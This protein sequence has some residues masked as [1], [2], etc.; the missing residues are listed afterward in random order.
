MAIRD[1]LLSVLK[2]REARRISFSL[3]A[4]NGITISV[5]TSSFQRVS[6]AIENNSV[7]IVEG[8]VAAGW[9]QYDSGNNTFSVGPG[10]HW[11]RAFNALLVHE[12]VHA[13][14]DLSRS[15]LPWL[16]N[17]TAAYIAQGYYLR[18]SGFSRNR[19]N[20]T[21]QPYLGLM[22][23]DSIISGGSPDQFWIS[24]LHGSLLSSRQY[25]SYIRTD[26]TGDG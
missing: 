22:I 9:A 15:S 13:S 12:A 21:G 6:D 11:S 2:G 1:Q 24:Q 18:N 5:D 4:S 19:L 20:T 7:S 3:T 23:V 25:H 17:E 26:F 14:F 10:Q 16:D 8:G